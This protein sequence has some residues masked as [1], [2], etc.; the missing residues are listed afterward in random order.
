MNL[1]SGKGH[2]VVDGIAACGV[3]LARCVD[4]EH[5]D[6]TCRHCLPI[7]RGTTMAKKDTAAAAPK[8]PAAKKQEKRPSRSACEKA[9]KQH[10]DA[11]LKYQEERGK[12]VKRGDNKF[13]EGYRAYKTAYRHLLD[14]RR[15]AG[16]LKPRGEKTPEPAAAENIDR[17]DVE[18]QVEEAP[19]A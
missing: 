19:A 13:R 10:K 15:E 4:S 12:G 14:Y 9:M 16:E 6:V 1:D 2:K 8:A 7:T 11:Y 17:G 5:A 18:Q 3:N